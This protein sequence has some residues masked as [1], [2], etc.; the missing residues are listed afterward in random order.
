MS[1]KICISGY[2]KMGKEVEQV[3][4]DNDWEVGAIIDHAEDWSLQK[5]AILNTDVIVDF[6]TPQCALENIKNALELKIPIV[7]GTTGWN[8]ALD[9]IKRKVEQKD[10]ALVYASNFSIGVNIFSKINESLAQ[11]MNQHP[12]Y[13]VNMEEIHHT[14]KLDQPSGTAISLAEEIL[15]KLSR[16]STW[17]NETSFQQDELSIISKRIE[18][19]P[20]T[21]IISYFSEIDEIEIKH[22]AK[23]RRGFAEGA[24][25]AAQWIT[26]KKGMYNFKDILFNKL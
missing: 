24:F 20:G 13:D 22:T 15:G 9:T 14:Q 11:L 8:K 5:E 19:V 25:Y 3:A 12:Q 21:H 1:R 16:K 17:I 26:D 4:L 2:G 6:S 18:D 23:S 10:G 7:I